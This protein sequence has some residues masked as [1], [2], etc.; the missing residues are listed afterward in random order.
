MRAVVGRASRGAQRGHFLEQAELV[1]GLPK[2]VL[3]VPRRERAGARG[4]RASAA[5][6]RRRARSR[7]PAYVDHHGV[8]ADA[9]PASDEGW[10]LPDRWA[11]LLHDHLDLGDSD[12]LQGLLVGCSGEHRAIAQGAG[13]GASAVTRR[14]NQE[15]CFHAA[16]VGE[17]RRPGT[18]NSIVNV[19]PDRSLLFRARRRARCASATP[20]QIARPSPVP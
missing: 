14:G 16:V 17:G 1:F 15:Y 13:V 19:L 2:H 6:L 18:G 20:R 3:E 12:G 4:R 11:C 8:R 10:H 7:R 9:S 5:G